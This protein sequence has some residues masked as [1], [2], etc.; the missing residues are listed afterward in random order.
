VI[1][2][3]T[4]FPAA[5]P[6]GM[7]PGTSVAIASV[8]AARTRHPVFVAFVAKCRAIG[9]DSTAISKPK[10]PATGNGL[11]GAGQRIGPA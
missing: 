10:W 6:A 11:I 2:S 1:T 3:A 9:L 4:K 7:A 8:N 5:A